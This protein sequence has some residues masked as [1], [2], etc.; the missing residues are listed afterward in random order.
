MRCRCACAAALQRVLA[1]VLHGLLARRECA[2][3]ARA[4]V[5]RRPRSTVSE[6]VGTADAFSV[7]SSPDRLAACRSQRLPRSCA[8]RRLPQPCAMRS[9]EW[10]D[11]SPAAAST[12]RKT[13]SFS[14]VTSVRRS[15]SASSAKR[16]SGAPPLSRCAA[17]KPD[18]PKRGG[19]SLR[20]LCE[21][22]RRRMRSRASQSAA[23]AHSSPSRGM[24]RSAVGWAAASA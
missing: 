3:R 7:V 9:K 19:H 21:S 20:R 24:C 10:I 18:V 14:A 15:S 4:C 12:R 2:P 1:Q 11:R 16:L 17:A 13:P 23:G 22:G 8:H 5:H 6:C